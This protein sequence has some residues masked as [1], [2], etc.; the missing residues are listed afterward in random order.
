MYHHVKTIWNGRKVLT[1]LVGVDSRKMKS[2]SKR[3]LFFMNW[4]K[5]EDLERQSSKSDEKV[6]YLPS[7]LNQ[8][9]EIQ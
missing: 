1:M 4:L 7:L 6:L 9:S 2:T 8:N 5:M 3:Q